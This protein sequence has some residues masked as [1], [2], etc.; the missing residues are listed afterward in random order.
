MTVRLADL[1]AD[2]R[3]LLAYLD[4]GAEGRDQLGFVVDEEIM[5]LDHQVADDLEAVGLV[6]IVTEPS[7]KDAYTPWYRLTDAGYALAA[8]IRGLK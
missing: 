7:G 3:R 5:R 8:H 4:T 1:S 6:E 2:Q